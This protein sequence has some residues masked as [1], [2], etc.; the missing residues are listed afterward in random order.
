M[1]S[2]KVRPGLERA[3]RS[4]PSQGTVTASVTVGVAL[5]GPGHLDT[6]FIVVLPNESL[7]ILCELVTAGNSRDG[8]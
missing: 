5:T 2:R 8:N 4:I 3:L 1:R 7:A 6:G